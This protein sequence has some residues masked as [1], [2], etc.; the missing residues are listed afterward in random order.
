[1]ALGRKFPIFRIPIAH[2][3]I[4]ETCYT[5]AAYSL[6]TGLAEIIPV[7]TIPL[8]ITDMIVLSK[9]QAFLVYKLGLTLGFSTRWQ[10]YI[11]EFGGVL[12]SGF[13]WRQIARSLIG[14][15]PL[16]GIIP[17]V[18]VAYAG[19][20]V[21]G[22]VVLQW[23]IT[24]RHLSKKQMQELYY[25]SLHQGKETARRI[26]SRMPKIRFPRLKLPRLK[27]RRLQR[28]SVRLPRLPSFSSRKKR[29]AKAMVASQECPECGRLSA[30]DAVLCQYCGFTF[31]EILLQE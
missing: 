19:T 30:E 20:Y 13:M 26:L 17:K 9:N 31:G 5:N 7:L 24:G 18:G 23:Y 12:G 16:W 8:T 2:Y 15:V 6:S 3:L 11:A 22:N 27:L 29:Q 14:L 4:N 25:R 1:M 21:V 28:P 10:D